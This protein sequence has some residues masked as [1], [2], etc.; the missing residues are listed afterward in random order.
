LQAHGFAVWSSYFLLLDTREST[1]LISLAYSICLAT[2][3]P[4]AQLF[5]V[6]SPTAH[7]QLSSVTSHGCQIRNGVF[8]MNLKWSLSHSECVRVIRRRKPRRG[9]FEYA[10]MPCRSRLDS[11]FSHRRPQKR[12]KVGT[13]LVLT[14]RW[15]AGARDA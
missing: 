10:H 6:L 9:H 15:L 14:R 1:N 13:E 8:L 5:S 12:P 11:S 7:H 3:T 2:N 4:T